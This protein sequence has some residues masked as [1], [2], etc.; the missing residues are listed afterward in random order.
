MITNRIATAPPRIGNNSGD[1][2]SE[3]ASAVAADGAILDGLR[4]ADPPGPF[5]NKRLSNDLRPTLFLAQLPNLL[6]GNI[7]IVHKVTGSSRT[8]M[9][10]EIAG[11]SAVEVAWRRIAAGQGDV[12][13]VDEDEDVL[14]EVIVEEAGR[15]D[16]D[17]DGGEGDDLA[18]EAGAVGAEGEAEQKEDDDRV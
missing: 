11:I 8:F 16:A 14:G 12:F 4:T 9:G 3:S 18:D 7:S 5:L 6:A 15:Y 17:E 1:P 2:S 13:V 10:E